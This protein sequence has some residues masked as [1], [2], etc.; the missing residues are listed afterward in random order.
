MQYA[1]A[2]FSVALAL[3]CATPASAQQDPGSPSDGA[4]SAT[5]AVTAAQE[6]GTAP[7]D[8]PRRRRPSV[9]DVIKAVAPPLID[10]ATRPP[11][12]AKPAE[13]PAPP[14]TPAADIEPVPPAAVAPLAPAQAELPRPAASEASNAPLPTKSAPPRPADPVVAQSA[15]AA[16]TVPVTAEPQLPVELP[17]PAPAV[18]QAKPAATPAPAAEEEPAI[19]PSE[20]SHNGSN[21][22]WLLV[23]LLV[24]AAVA[25]AAMLRLH[26]LRQIAR[27][28]SLLSLD[29]RLER[30]PALSPAAVSARLLPDPAHG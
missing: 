14:E 23:G 1:F 27:T 29:V 28:R 24:L 30:S 17:P 15:P 18:D 21:I 20:P 12:A 8:Q 7:I 16:P 13:Q 19:V 26:Q 25:A 22:S 4:S 3:L 5:G 2:A 6:P 11:P 9:F 10:A